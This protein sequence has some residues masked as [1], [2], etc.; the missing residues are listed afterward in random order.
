MSENQEGKKIYHKCPVCG[1]SGPTVGK[2]RALGGKWA[3]FCGYPCYFSTLPM[4]TEEEAL[5]EWDRVCEM[6]EDTQRNRNVMKEHL[7]QAERELSDV[8]A[9]ITAAGNFARS[10][11]RLESYGRL[12]WIYKE[13]KRLEHHITE[14]QK[15]LGQW[16]N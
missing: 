4:D 12:R 15:L 11:G 10:A 5:A 6:W 14:E 1:K 16:D 3:A 2:P 7:Q 9:H 13:L 8:R